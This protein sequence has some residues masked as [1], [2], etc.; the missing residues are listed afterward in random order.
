MSDNMTAADLRA[1]LRAA[2][3]READ[4]KKALANSV[5]PVYQF[6]LVST[7]EPFARLFPDSGC[8]VYK[9]TGTVVNRAEMDAVGA[10]INEGSMN[11]I[12]NHVSGTFVCSTGG[13]R[14][15]LN[16]GTFGHA[17]DTD[18]FKALADYLLDVSIEG[19]DV[20]EIV[21]PAHNNRMA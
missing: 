18:T 20:T 15:W 7:D 8:S 4:E 5:Q 3:L 12:F 21:L 14:I 10:K 11:Y 2:E 9:L 1:A 6:T 19:G 13:G 17:Y 16:D